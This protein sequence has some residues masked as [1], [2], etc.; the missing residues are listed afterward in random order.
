MCS[1]HI[2]LWRMEDINR[3]RI[4]VDWCNTRIYTWRMSGGQERL[5]AVFLVTKLWM[6]EAYKE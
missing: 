2:G 3:E 1:F 6:H 5:S 4:N